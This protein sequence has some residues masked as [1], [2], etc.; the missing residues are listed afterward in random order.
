MIG[1]EALLRWHHPD[2]RHDLARQ[3]SFRSPKKTNRSS[4]S[5]NGRFNT[6]CT[7][8][9][10]AGRIPGVVAV[11]VSPVQFARGD[12]VETIA[13]DHCAKLGLDARRASRSR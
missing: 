4:R 3:N 11:N 7:E 6:A 12:L 2:P 8:A 13:T 5:E 1:A 9:A 10:A